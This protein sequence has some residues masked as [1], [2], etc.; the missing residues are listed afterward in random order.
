MKKHLR[1][2][3]LSAV[4]LLAIAAFLSWPVAGWLEARECWAPGDARVDA[5]Y[6]LAGNSDGARGR[7]V[8]AWLQGGGKTERILLPHDSMKGP[9][10]R[11]D[12]RNLTMGEW[13]LRRL[14]EALAE[15]GLDVP[16]EVVAADMGGTDAE[17]ASVVRLVADRSDLGTVALAT[18]R[19]HVRRT[20]QRAK[21][22]FDDVPVMIPGVEKWYDRAPWVVGIELLKMLRDRL[23]LTRVVRRRSE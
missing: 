4:A 1:T 8:V 9:W 19:F 6:I 18:S 15:A 12:Q 7:G 5:V 22:H 10:S 3:A 20:H 23:G 13:A 2:F 21:K 11:R 16:V 14:T 17:V